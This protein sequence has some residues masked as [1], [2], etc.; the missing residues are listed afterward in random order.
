MLNNAFFV[1]QYHLGPKLQNTKQLEGSK[2]KMSNVRTI[3]ISYSDL[4]L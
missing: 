2:N 4:K 3:D 1:S